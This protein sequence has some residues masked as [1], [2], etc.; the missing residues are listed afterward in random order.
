MKE[1]AVILGE[2]SLSEAD[3]KYVRFAQEFEEKFITQKTS[4]HRPIEET[5][6][7]GWQLLRLLPPEELKRV[8]SEHVAKYLPA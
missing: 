7:L 8:K 6:K 1:L 4:E 2:S 5:L 3:R